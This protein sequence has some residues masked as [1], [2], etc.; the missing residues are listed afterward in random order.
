MSDIHPPPSQRRIQNYVFGIILI[1]LFVAMLT[2]FAPIFTALL[3]STLLYI[4]ISPLHRRVIRNLNF[5]T[6]KGKILRNFWAA[7]FTLGTILLILF[8][9]SFVI[10]VFFRQIM[11]MVRFAR[12]ILNARPEYLQEIFEKLAGI[13]SD[14]SAGQMYVTADDIRHQILSFLTTQQQRIFYLGGS[15]LKYLGGFS[16]NLLLMA[17]SMFFFFVDGPYLA[18]LVLRAIPIKNEYITTLTGK[19]L[20]TTRNLFLG[21]IIVAALQ[22]VVAFIIFTIFGVKGSLVLAV[23]T[24][25]LVFVPMFGAA[26]I[27]LSLG[28]FRIA[29]GDIAGGIVFLIISAVFISGIDNFLRPFF[30]KDRIRLHPLI[31][32]FAIF[33]GLAAFG[34]NGFVL[35]PVLVIFFLTVLDM[36]LAEHKIGPQ[37]QEKIP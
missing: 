2:L 37:D 15:I 19:F 9:L 12:D 7:V 17:F 24:F 23:I 16:I 11:E 33:G 32:L 28:I 20:D 3:W 25:F 8:P 26:V 30:L 18:R 5:D 22:S 36:F 27:W 1:L 14:V 35:G 13:I 4:L 21:Y 6:W 34:F 29:G 10:T 31:I